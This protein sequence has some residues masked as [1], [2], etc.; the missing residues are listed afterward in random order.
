MQKAICERNIGGIDIF[1]SVISTGPD[2]FCVVQVKKTVVSIKS[3]V[4]VFVYRFEPY[5][6]V[7][8]KC[9]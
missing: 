7:F 6:C 9:D 2:H 3:V 4:V 1:P 5:G 8:S